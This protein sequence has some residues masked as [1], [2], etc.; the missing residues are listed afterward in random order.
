MS[1]LIEVYKY[2]IESLKLDNLKLKNKNN[3]IYKKY[4]NMKRSN[5]RLKKLI[6]NFKKPII[7]ENEENIDENW[8]CV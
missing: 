8:D 6:N 1:E 5:L 3:N 7:L 2:E 4:T